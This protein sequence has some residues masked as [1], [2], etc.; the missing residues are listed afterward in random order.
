MMDI[1]ERLEAQR[2]RLEAQGIRID[3]H[4]EWLDSRIADDEQGFF[5]TPISELIT[6]AYRRIKQR[7]RGDNNDG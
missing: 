3:K 1:D 5:T 6:N 4:I 7:L 2:I